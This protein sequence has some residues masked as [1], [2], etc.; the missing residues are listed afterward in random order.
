MKNK[1]VFSLCQEIF[2]KYGDFMISFS[3]KPSFA[4]AL[5]LKL[6]LIS[7]R[8]CGLPQ[9]EAGRKKK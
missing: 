4:K 8:A 2:S 9:K 6:P 1:K 5:N 3:Y 7:N